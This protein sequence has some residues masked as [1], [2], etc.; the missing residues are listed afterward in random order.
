MNSHVLI[1][2]RAPN[3]LIELYFVLGFLLFKN[4]YCKKIHNVND[5]ETEMY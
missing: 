1:I 4:T 5:T 3:Q 2:L